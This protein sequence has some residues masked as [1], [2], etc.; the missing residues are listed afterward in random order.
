LE[1]YK[2]LLYKVSFKID[3]WHKRMSIKKTGIFME[4]KDFLQLDHSPSRFASS[5]DHSD[6]DSQSPKE[7]DSQVDIISNES[8]FGSPTG[9]NQSLDKLR[10][11]ARI[12][13][14]NQ[15]RVHSFSPKKMGANETRTDHFEIKMQELI[16]SKHSMNGALQK[17]KSVNE[18]KTDSG[19]SSQTQRF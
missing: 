10:T 14:P 16:D 7:Q 5:V 8:A 6:C 18:N 2:S 19:V 17:G 3:K 15:H 9:F 13:S 1:E 11:R 12:Y 4:D